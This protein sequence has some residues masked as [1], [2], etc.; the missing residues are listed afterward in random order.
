M[1]YGI[2]IGHNSPPDTGAVG[3]YEDEL[4]LELA[5]KVIVKLALFG[6]EALIVN[7]KGRVRSVNESLKIRCEN[8]NAAKVERY[9]SFHFNAFNKKARGVEIYYA[10]TAG[11]RIAKPVLEEICKLS[12]NSGRRF[13]NRGIKKTSLFQVLNGTNAPAILIETCFCDNPED[14]EIYREIGSDRVATAIVKGLTG[15][16]PKFDDQ[17]SL[18]IP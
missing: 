6:D 13:T 9:V 14:M 15:Q 3:G 8:A 18:Y 2:D 11:M 1:R 17:P 7:P 12:D 16:N 4:N 10:S 5:N